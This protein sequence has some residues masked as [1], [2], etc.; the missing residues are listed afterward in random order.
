MLTFRKDNRTQQLKGTIPNGRTR[1]REAERPQRKIAF[2]RARYQLVRAEV[3]FGCQSR[4]MEKHMDE[5]SFERD[6]KPLF[7]PIDLEHMEPMDVFLD[8]YDYMSDPGNAQNVHDWLT[9]AKEPQMPIGGPYWSKEQ[10]DLFSRW[11]SGGYK[12]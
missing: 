2:S 10:L 4:C 6:I 5:V 11:M 3:N 8:D 1:S 9:G 12:K 7:R